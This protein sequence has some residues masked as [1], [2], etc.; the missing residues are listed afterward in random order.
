MAEKKEQSEMWGE[1]LREAGV[2]VLVFGFL[3]QFMKGGVT[4]GGAVLVLGVS[5]LFQIIGMA[6]ERVRSTEREEV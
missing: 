1:F 6:I 3:D 5:M 2:L 4:F